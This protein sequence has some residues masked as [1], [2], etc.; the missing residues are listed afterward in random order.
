MTIAIAFIMLAALQMAWGLTGSIHRPETLVLLD[1]SEEGLGKSK[2]RARRALVFFFV[3][4]VAFVLSF[5]A[6]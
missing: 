6:R 1:N 4:L 5:A 3:G 2:V